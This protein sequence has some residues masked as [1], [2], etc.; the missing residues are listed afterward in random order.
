MGVEERVVGDVPELGFVAGVIPEGVRAFNDSLLE[1]FKSSQVLR[2]ND[3]RVV[4]LNSL[5][6]VSVG[7][8]LVI[9][10]A[11]RFTQSDELWGGSLFAVKVF[12]QDVLLTIR[13]SEW[14]TS[15]RLTSDP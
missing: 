5:S 4:H 7:S 1:H 9:D 13:F 2:A 10:T 8:D 12:P 11:I 6:L 15:T 3:F 14:H